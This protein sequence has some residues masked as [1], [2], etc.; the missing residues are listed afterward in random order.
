MDRVKAAGLHILATLGRHS[1]DEMISFYFLAP[2]EIAFEVGYDGKTIEYRGDSEIVA[3]IRDLEREI[4]KLNGTE[5]VRQIR[6]F[7]S[8]GY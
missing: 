6:T 5:P 8:K 7:T 3:A 2:G 1:N 4:S